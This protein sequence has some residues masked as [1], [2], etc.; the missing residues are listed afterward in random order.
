MVDSRSLVDEVI[1]RGRLQ[2]LS[3][4]D[5]SNL[6]VEDRGAP[7]HVA[8]LLILERLPVVGSEGPTGLAAVRAYIQGRLHLAPRLRQV[9]Y[10]PPPGLGRPVWLDYPRFD[11]SQHVRS[12]SVSVPGDEA[13][14]LNECAK[15]Y[16]TPLDRSRPLWEIWLLTGLAGD[17]AALFIRLHHVL[18]DGTA[19]LAMLSVLCQPD[20]GELPGAPKWTPAAVPTLR[21]FGADR[22]GQVGSAVTGRCRPAA[23]GASFRRMAAQGAALA[24]EGRAPRLSLNAAVSGRRQLALVRTDLAA[25]RT[26]AHEHGGTV[27]DA[28]LAAVAGGARAL[29]GARGEL[30]PTMVVKASVAASL[31]RDADRLAGGNRVG[32]LI[33]P[34]PVGEPDAGRRLTQIVAAT[35]RRKARPPYQPSSRLLLRWMIRGMPRERLV[36][37]LVSNLPGPQER[38]WFA[39]TEV[40]ELVQFGVVQGN[41]PISVGAHSYAGQLTLGVVADGAITDLDV[42]VAGM[43]QAVD[44]F[45]ARAD[46]QKSRSY[47][48]PPGPDLA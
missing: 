27:N 6:R 15:L 33:A 47:S 32:V 14:L 7:M 16:E 3:W 40:L 25:A 12:N 21:D 34:L 37:L 11:I 23:V 8:A 10:Q 9:I 1:K 39:G 41:V 28:V 31:R 42:F 5:L 26:V 22:L 48:K 36:N 2:R 46:A 45:A 30:T 4:L 38:L 18:D 43:T 13:A 44:D 17:R 24:G 19:A 29:L 35:R 20:A